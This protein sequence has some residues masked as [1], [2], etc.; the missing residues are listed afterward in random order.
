MKSEFVLSGKE[1]LTKMVW[2]FHF[3]ADELP[4][5]TAGQYMEWVL[6]HDS[7]DKRGIRRFFTICSSPMEKDLMLATKIIDKPSSF[8][9]K[10]RDMN[11]GDPITARDVDGDFVLPKNP[12]EKLVFIAGGIGITP[13]RSMVKYLLDM[14]EKC[15]IVLLYSN[16]G[17]SDVA[18]SGLFKD[19]EKIGLKT[20]NFF[21]K[22]PKPNKHTYEVEQAVSGYVDEIAIKKYVADWQ[23]RTFYVS[24]PEPMVEAFEKM[25]QQMGVKG[26]QL[27]TD[28]F[29]G[30]SETYQSSS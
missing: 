7:A 18:F 17:S 6:P 14:G 23:E 22:N 19:A 10:L 30:Y 12:Q 2:A 29:P 25:L 27:K 11:I 5:W 15:D 8:K 26:R 13:F 1:Q 24:G 28:Y 9:A 20:I 16:K 21:T 4:N 3:T